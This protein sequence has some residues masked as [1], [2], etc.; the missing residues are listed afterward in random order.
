MI[1]VGFF[2]LVA[3]AVVVFAVWLVV[4]GATSGPDRPA[5]EPDRHGEL[6]RD[7]AP[8]TLPDPGA[9]RPAG[10]GA[11]GMYVAGDGDISPGPPEARSARESGEG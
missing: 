7:D 6:P 8:G 1:L 10:A 4:R 5:L 11:E 3:V 2:V 9:D